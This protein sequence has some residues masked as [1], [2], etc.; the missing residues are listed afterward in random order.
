MSKTMLKRTLL[1][2]F[3][4]AL[5]IM[6]ASCQSDGEG[7][8]I[9][10][11]EPT[12]TPIPDQPIV[13]QKPTFEVERG[14][15]VQ[16]QELIGRVG[17]LN[18]TTI[19]FGS[20]GRVSELYFY[21]GDVV[22]EGDLI[23]VYDHLEDLERDTTLREIAVRR[24][25]IS[26]ERAQLFLDMTLENLWATDEEIQ[27][28]EWDLEL[29]QL[30]YQELMLSLGDQLESVAAAKLV[31][32]MDGM[33]TKSSVRVNQIFNDTQEV[34]TIADMNELIIL[35]DSYTT[36][37]EALK[38]GMQ[39]Q[40]EVYNGSDVYE[41]TIIQMP[42]PYGTGPAR[43]IDKFIYIDFDNAADGEGWDINDRFDITAE[44]TRVED[45]LMLPIEA[46]REFSGRTFVM[47]Q[48]GDMQVSIDITTG[49]TDGIMVEV[50]EGLEEGQIVIG[51]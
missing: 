42:Y 9:G 2:S 6:T 50:L 40:L 48:E 27:L 43:D 15:I 8:S 20:E 18:T 44:I 13:I 41:G 1:F 26:V 25:E 21:E 49:L 51:Q 36:D 14:T 46:V 4:I 37:V 11:A 16:I 10:L 32:P 35:V 23:A 3:F 22:K 24:A 38:E 28:K 17:P 30:S 45:I 7:I 39:V 19:S 34:M 47:V 5:L 33:I 29:A 12:V 31:A